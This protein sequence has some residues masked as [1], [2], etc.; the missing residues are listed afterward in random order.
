MLITGVDLV[1]T[2]I[3][4]LI[5]C[6]VNSKVLDS[7]NILEHRGGRS[8]LKIKRDIITP[9]AREKYDESCSN[10]RDSSNNRP[11]PDPYSRTTSTGFLPRRRVGGIFSTVVPADGRRK[12]S[13]NAGSRFPGAK[14]EVQDIFLKD[15]NG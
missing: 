4:P 15:E 3:V 5:V 9:S 13:V 6:S 10:C 8:H 11:E 1:P 7:E 14:K 12:K 2:Q